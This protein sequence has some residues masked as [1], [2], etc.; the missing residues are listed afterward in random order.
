MVPPRVE[1]L[2]CADVPHG[3]LFVCSRHHP[4][5]GRGACLLLTYFLFRAPHNHTDARPPH[6]QDAS[7]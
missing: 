7:H 3:R 1:R 6:A 4:T 5:A 2:V